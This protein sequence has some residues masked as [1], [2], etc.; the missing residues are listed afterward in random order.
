MFKA[1]FT[2]GRDVNNID[3]LVAIS[4]DADLQE[5]DIREALESETIAQAVQKDIAE[6][7]TLGISGVPFFV[8]NRAYGISG[9]QPVE[10]FLQTLEQSYKEWQAQQ[11][12]VAMMNTD[13]PSCTPDGVCE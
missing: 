3:T 13:G 6:A 7:A 11:P 9:A 5:A 10:A 1:Y 4:K 8:F 12:Q 2:E